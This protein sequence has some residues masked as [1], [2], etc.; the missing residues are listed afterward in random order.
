MNFHIINPFKVD[1]QFTLQIH[2]IIDSITFKE[3]MVCGSTGMQYSFYSSLLVF[4]VFLQKLVLQGLGNAWRCLTSPFCENSPCNH[5]E[6]QSHEEEPAGWFAGGKRGN[7]HDGLHKM[8]PICPKLSD[9]SPGHP[10]LEYPGEIPFNLLHW[11][12]LHEA[13][14][15]PCPSGSH[16]PC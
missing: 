13:L 5:R 14:R 2:L 1:T 10:S 4:M 12:G 9:G 7:V 11:H 3:T 6:F 15:F 16:E 8:G